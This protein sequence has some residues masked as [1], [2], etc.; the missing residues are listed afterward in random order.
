VLP[1]IGHT[2]LINFLGDNAEAPVAMGSMYN[3]N[4]KSGF[5]TVDNDLKAFQTRSGTKIIFNDA[6][7]SILIEDPSGNRWHLDGQGNIS[8]DAPKTFTVNAGEDINLNA[9]RN[10]NTFAGE[11]HSSFAGAMMMQNAVADYSLTAANIIEQA[12]G[13]RKSK[14]KKVTDKSKKKKIVS[15]EKNEIHTQGT[16]HNNGGNKSNL[17]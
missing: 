15:K 10:M 8:V 7:G 16:F 1:E 13:E 17:H 2:V 6:E 9:G 14:A 3:G 5:H 12:K 4:Q 11:N